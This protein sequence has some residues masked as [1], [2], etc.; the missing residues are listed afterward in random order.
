MPATAALLFVKLPRPGRVKTRLAA[1]IGERLA[2][3]FYDAFAR[4]ER[5]ALLA[6]GL[7]VTACCAPDAPLAAYKRW[8]GDNVC[9]TRQRGEDIG[10]RMAN[11]FEDAFGRGFE[12]VVLTGSDSPHMPPSIVTDAASALE[13]HD[14]ALTPTPDGG[15]CLIAFTRRGFTRCA[16]SGVEWSTPQVMGET[17]SRLEGAGRS[18]F[19]LP[20][21][22]DIDTIADLKRFR[23]AEFSDSAA[24]RTRALLAEISLS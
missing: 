23:D 24:P 15:Y 17:V 5:D 13:V 21:V 2:A 11:A 18:V 22:G 8:L 9:Y 10:E 20:S 1:S 19:I 12:R 7:P 14:A 4:D 6:S 3:R 16:F